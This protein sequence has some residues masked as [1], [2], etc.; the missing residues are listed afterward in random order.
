V[1]VEYWIAPESPFKKAPCC[2]FAAN[3]VDTMDERKCDDLLILY[4]RRL[5][6]V[7]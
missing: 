4:Q 2:Q 7:R 5:T 1:W 3:R 6:V